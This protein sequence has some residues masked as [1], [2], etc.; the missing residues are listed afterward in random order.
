MTG[1]R[2]PFGIIISVCYLSALVAQWA[3]GCPCQGH[4]KPVEPPVKT[5]QRCPAETQSPCCQA[6][7][8]ACAE[9]VSDSKPSEGCCESKAGCHRCPRC[10]TW[11]AVSPVTDRPGT[12]LVVVATAAPVSWVGVFISSDYSLVVDHP[13]DRAGLARHI[14]TSVLRC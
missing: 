3:M 1:L 12:S 6:E 9:A 2:R 14:S 7:G 5:C 4:N 10:L 8:Q 13:P 11:D